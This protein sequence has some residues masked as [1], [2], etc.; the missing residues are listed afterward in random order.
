MQAVS[1]TAT[2]LIWWSA[3]IFGFQAFPGMFMEPVL[4]YS[5]TAKEN[6]FSEWFSETLLL[7]GKRSEASFSITAALKG[8]RL[9]PY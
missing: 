5:Q 1:Y 9:I 6:S 8:V 7:G 4:L 2:H 3:I